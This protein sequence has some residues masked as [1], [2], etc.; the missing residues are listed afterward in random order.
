MMKKKSLEEQGKEILRMAEQA[1]VQT[2]YFF[3]TTFERYQ[4]QLMILERLRKSLE[5]DGLIVTK[6]YV[7]G[8]QN[9]YSNPAVS[10][11]NRTTDGANRTVATLIKIIKS[12]G[13]NKTDDVDPLLELINGE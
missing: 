3:V 4:T 7:K 13:E 10:E 2:N 1:D 5:D 8:R 12:F 9:L 6:E 11:Y